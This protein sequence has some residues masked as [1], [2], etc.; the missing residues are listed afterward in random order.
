MGISG[1]GF[2]LVTAPLLLFVLEPKSVVVFNVFLGILV[3]LPVLWQFRHYIHPKR[4]S[5]L[6]LSSILGLPLGIYAISRLSSPVLKIII[7]VIVVIFSLLM[8]A[9]VSVKIKRENIGCGIA[10]FISGSLS[11]S[12]GLNGPPIVL[13]LLNQGW[14]PEAFKGNISLYFVLNGIAAAISLGVTG[15]VSSDLLTY[16]ATTIPAMIIGYY[17]GIKLLPRIKAASFRKIAICVLLVC[18]TL[19][20]IDAVV[21]WIF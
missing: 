6:F 1:F 5:I 11:N 10:G 2:V 13:F 12:V 14:S 9:G 8:A 18:S 16:T 7:I 19:A 17:A 20:V 21:T 4:V 15:N 3:C